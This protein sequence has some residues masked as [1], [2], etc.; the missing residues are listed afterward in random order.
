MADHQ[1]GATSVWVRDEG[2]NWDPT[3]IVGGGAVG[4]YVPLVTTHLNK[5]LAT[6][7]GSKFFPAITS[8]GKKQ[9]IYYNGEDVLN[10][11]AAFGPQ[12]SANKAM[13]KF[14]GEGDYVGV[15]DQLLLGLNDA[16]G[17]G[18]AP[19]ADQTKQWFCRQ[20]LT[21]QLHRW[22]PATT[23]PNSP[24]NPMGH[25]P[26]T[27]QFTGLENQTLALL[28]QWLKGSL[29]LRD[30]ETFDLAI[31][32]LQD[33]LPSG[34][35]GSTLIAYNPLKLG[36]GVTARP[37]ECALFHEL[38]HAYYNAE[39]SQLSQ[40]D[41]TTEHVGRYYELMSVG[42]P[43]FDTRPYSENIMRAH[44]ACPLRAQY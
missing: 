2:P 34:N 44:F 4:G 28:N 42:L 15:R 29:Q 3:R 16:L 11:N 13:R 33:Y 18:V 9:V 43:P 24:L 1:F 6:A 25:M 31:L 23:A 38:V 20:L 7:A 8:L 39:G 21:T 35:G 30:E 36:A 32:I 19:N 17:K 26:G 40:E 10:E 12:A 14:F 5:I 27:P 37:P 41:S 22:N